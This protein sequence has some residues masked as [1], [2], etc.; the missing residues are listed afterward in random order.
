METLARDDELRA[1]LHRMWN[2]VAAGW[3]EHAEFTDRR[4]AAVTDR[5]LELASLEPGERVLDV[6]TGAGGMG[7]AAAERVGPGGEVVLSDVAAEMVAIA[8]R[9]AEAR[10]LGNVSA[11]VL[12]LERIDEPD[13][14]YDVVFCREGIMLVPDPARAA[15]EIRR[16]LR[17]DG[18]AALAV[19]GPRERNPWLGVVFAAVTAELG[20]PV[21]PTGTP[22]PFSLD[23][24]VRFAS[25]LSIAG[26]ADV[27]VEEVAVPYRAGTVDEWWART[28]ALAGPLAQ[29]LA[30]LPEPA[31]RALRERAQAEIGV[32]ETARGLDIPGVALVAAASG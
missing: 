30:V 20:T 15:E 26:L 4:G 27:R 12:D 13:E 7:L 29:R 25:L 32:Y 2:G 1:Q 17:P 22:G 18:R 28:T 8:G 21:P 24:P 6:A 23:D 9:R 31:A 16:V 19:W 14:S 3:A 10:G 5:L 11:R